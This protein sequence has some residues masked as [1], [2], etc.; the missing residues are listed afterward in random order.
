[1]KKLPTIK[2]ARSRNA[3]TAYYQFKCDLRKNTGD[4]LIPKDLA[5]SFALVCNEV[6]NAL[7]VEK[8]SA[9]IIAGTILVVEK[10]ALNRKRS[11]WINSDSNY[12]TADWKMTENM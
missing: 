9:G 7:H 3:I 5:E 4:V 11:G 8:L 1:M 2:T 6:L 10:M 12:Y